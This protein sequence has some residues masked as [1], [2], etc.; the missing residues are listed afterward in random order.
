MTWDVLQWTSD[1][2]WTF[3]SLKRFLSILTSPPVP[4]IISYNQPSFTRSHTCSKW[5][6]RHWFIQ[7]ILFPFSVF[8][9]CG[10]EVPPGEVSPGL[11]REEREVRGRRLDLSPSL[12]LMNT[13]SFPQE[14]G[15]FTYE[16]LDFHTHKKALNQQ[17]IIYFIKNVNKWEV[18]YGS[19]CITVL[20]DRTGTGYDFTVWQVWEAASFVFFLLLF[21]NMQNVVLTSVTWRLDHKSAATRMTNLQINTEVFGKR[22]DRNYV[23]PDHPLLFHFLSRRRR[24]SRLAPLIIFLLNLSLADILALC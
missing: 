19:G 5:H 15:I 2:M 22:K 12:S 1:H 10:G 6:D 7:M 24:R 17:Q 4:L 14:S 16:A 18:F 9:G 20:R 21:H 23:W 8:Q 11:Q 13:R 3:C